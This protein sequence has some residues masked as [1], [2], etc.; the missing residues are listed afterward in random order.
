MASEGAQPSAADTG[1]QGL[2]AGE[3]DAPGVLVPPPVYFIAALAIGFALE[4]LV[5][6]ASLSAG[7]AWPVGGVL[8]VGGLFLG[9]AF[10]TAF[11]R[12]GT[13]VDVRKS[14]ET[15]VTTGPYRLSRNPGYLSLALIY[16][17]IAILTSALWAF[18]PLIPT[19]ILVDRAVI[20]REERYLERKFG[21]EY[22]RYKASTRRW[23]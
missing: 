7:L 1:S 9:A 20:R 10:L 8:L 19:L 15:I 16:A 14:T 11:R 2:G 5:P 21:G 3:R 12:A 13:P 23:I 17:G 22:T 18:V 6:S 4:A